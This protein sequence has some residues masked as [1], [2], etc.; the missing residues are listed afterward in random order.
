[1]QFSVKYPDTTSE[2]LLSVPHYNFNWQRAYRLAQPKHIPAGSVLRLDAAWD[3]SSLNKANPDP[4]R[5]VTWGEQSFDEMFFGTYRFVEARAWDRRT[6]LKEAKV[7]P[8][9]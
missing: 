2:V 9:R 5:T 3:N 1:M 8:P 4:N 6:R 7:F